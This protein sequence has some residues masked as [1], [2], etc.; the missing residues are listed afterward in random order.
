MPRNPTLVCHSLSSDRWGDFETLFGKNGACGGCWCACWRRS[1][2]DFVN[3]KGAGNKR[4]MLK[5]VEAGEPTG[6]L[7]YLDE[8]PVAW[9]ALAPRDDYPALERSRILKP[10]DET[11]VWSIT[12]FFVRKDHRRKGLTVQ[13][14]RAAVERVRSCGG[15]IV[16]GYP[17]EPRLDNV[18]PVFAWVGL[19]PA[20]LA[21]GFHEVARRSEGRP[22]MRCDVTS[23]TRKK[24][25]R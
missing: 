2:S 8:E 7:G 16:E 6:I 5:V 1:R 10:V 22:I 9:C 4:F 21:A 15:T 14:L 18:P 3:G 20:F 23:A 24:R 13:L 11:P 17:I 12:C 19:S 25:K